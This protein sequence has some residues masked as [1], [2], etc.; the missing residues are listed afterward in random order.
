MSEKV[1]VVKGR[2]LRVDNW[3]RVILDRCANEHEHILAPG[4]P[5]NPDAGRRRCALIVDEKIFPDTA[6]KKGRFFITVKF[7]SEDDDR[8]AGVDPVADYGFETLP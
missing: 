5:T 6:G 2:L 3:G 4:D 8:F 1:T 7:V